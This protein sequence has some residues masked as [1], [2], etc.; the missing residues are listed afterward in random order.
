MVQQKFAKIPP[1]T[2]SWEGL[3]WY[4]NGYSHSQEY[5]FTLKRTGKDAI[6]LGEYALSYD[7]A[8]EMYTD[9]VSAALA[10]VVQK[11]ARK[12]GVGVQTVVQV[13]VPNPDGGDDIDLPNHHIE[14]VIAWLRYVL[15]IMLYTD[16]P[17]TWEY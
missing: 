17:K 9:L 7:E 2:L 16:D 3:G 1:A 4:N 8:Y 15:G 6:L 5:E 13:T 12:H 11:G 10:V 14:E